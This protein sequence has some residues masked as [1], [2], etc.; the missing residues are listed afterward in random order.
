MKTRIPTLFAATL[1][2]A[3]VTP[4]VQGAEKAQSADQTNRQ[5]TVVA[6]VTEEPVQTRTVLQNQGRAGYHVRIERKTP[7]MADDYRGERR[8]ALAVETP[9]QPRIRLQS[10]G[11]AGYQYHRTTDRKSAD[12]R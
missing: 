4:A 8:I 10:H 7:A 1:L 6:V 11:R 9:S 12:F 2:A 3:L 5:D